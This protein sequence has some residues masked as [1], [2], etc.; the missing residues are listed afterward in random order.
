MIKLGDDALI[1]DVKWDSNS[2]N[3]LVGCQNGHVYEVRKPKDNE[4][5]N[6]ETFLVDNIPIR[7]WKIKMMEF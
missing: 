4:I 6:N 5:D 1:N 7:D 3:L 2:S